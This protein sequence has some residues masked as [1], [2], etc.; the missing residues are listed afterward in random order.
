MYDPERYEEN[1]SAAKRDA[2]EHVPE[3]IKQMNWITENEDILDYGC[4][5]G[6]VTYTYFL[7]MALRYNSS[8]TAVDV[9]D[10]MIEHAKKTY[11]HPRIE[12]LQGNIMAKDFPLK[13]RQF[14]KIFS[15]YVLHFIKDYRQA[16]KNFYDLLKPM[17]NLDLLL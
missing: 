17:D 13:G 16:F 7:P 8:I 14:D 4:G 9:S 10:K 15:V 12:Y 5:A 3:L 2:D 6:S 11:S 1:K